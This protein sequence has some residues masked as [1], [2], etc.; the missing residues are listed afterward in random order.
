[1]T[2]NFALAGST[3]GL[4]GVKEQD[5]GDLYK[6]MSLVLDEIKREYSAEVTKIGLLGVSM[7]GLDG[8]Y[9]SELD[10][11]KHAIGIS[12]F[13]LINPPLFYAGQIVDELY[14][15]GKD[16]SEEV[17]RSSIRSLALGSDPRV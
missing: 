17:K 16:W 6:V 4:P 14:A 7:G 10:A 5:V 1:M 3:T 11:R 15:E 13:L 8:A 12:R 2:W 9:L